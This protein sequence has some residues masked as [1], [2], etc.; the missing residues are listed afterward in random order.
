ML[1]LWGQSGSGSDSNEGVLHIPQSSSITATSPSDCLVS[2]SGH[3][4]EVGFFTPLQ[5]S[6]R[7]ILQPQLTGQECNWS[8]NKLTTVAVKHIS[9]Y[10]METPQQLFYSIVTILS[11][12]NIWPMV[13]SMRCSVR[14]K[15]NNYGLLIQFVNHYTT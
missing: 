4:L 9:H 15:L 14:F 8:M 5:K 11:L 3:S 2:Y 10:T 12:P 6:S 1:P 7:C 13:K